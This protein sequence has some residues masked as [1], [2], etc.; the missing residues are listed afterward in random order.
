MPDIKLLGAVYP[1]VPA[2]D[3]PKNPSGTAR[4]YDVTGTTATAKDVIAGKYFYDENGVLTMGELSLAPDV[5]YNS[6]SGTT[7][8]VTLSATA[9]NYNHMRIYFRHT[10]DD[11]YGSVDVYSPN[12]KTVQ[13]TIAETTSYHGWLLGRAV[14]IS[15]TSITTHNGNN[16]GEGQV[17][18][19]GSWSNSNNIGITRVE[20]WN[21]ST[22]F[23]NIYSSQNTP[24]SSDGMN[25]D[26]WMVT[27]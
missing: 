1:D 16:Y 3:L 4:F 18:G 15:G 22:N 13:L 17:D 25:G 27:S 20:A 11:F 7:G 9:A 23:A 10:V 2:V 8:T 19:S 12:G 14:V 6:T 21:D 24:T 5:L 26:I